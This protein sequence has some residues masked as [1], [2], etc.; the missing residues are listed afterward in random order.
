LAHINQYEYLLQIWFGRGFVIPFAEKLCRRI[1]ML[2]RA[3]Q[4]HRAERP[5]K[6]TSPGF[7][8]R[9]VRSSETLG[10]AKS[11][12]YRESI[13]NHSLAQLLQAGWSIETQ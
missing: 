12:G 8:A 10:D 7:R 6:P 13:L 9:G 4:Q 2:N 3:A 11:Q 5:R 1:Q